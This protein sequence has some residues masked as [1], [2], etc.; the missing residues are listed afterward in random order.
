MYE[1]I[2]MSYLKGHPLFAGETEQK[3]LEACSLSKIKTVYRGE[4]FNYGNGNYSKIFLLL[5]GKIKISESNEPDNELIKDIL[6]S[7]DVFGDLGL[8]CIP[9]IEE[10]AE[11]LTANTTV[12]V[13]N[14]VDFKILLQGNPTMAIKYANM[15]NQKLKKLEHRHYELVF[16]DAKSRLISFIKFWAQSDGSRIGDKIILNNYLTHSDIAAVISISRQSV[17]SLLN[18]LRDSGLLIYDRKK[19]ELNNLCKW[20]G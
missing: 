18:E 15:V 16:R 13:F 5:N 19:I 6:T 12:F 1:E 10:F 2:K 11:A 8:E 4:T 3:I 14:V 17:N 20:T 7:P 9:P